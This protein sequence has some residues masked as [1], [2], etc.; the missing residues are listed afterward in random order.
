M[1]SRALAR[2][3]PSQQ[4]ECCSSASATGEDRT[5]EGMDQHELNML[6]KMQNAVEEEARREKPTLSEMC[7]WVDAMEARE[8]NAVHAASCI[9]GYVPT[10]YVRSLAVARALYRFME[11]AEK[12]REDVEM[13]FRATKHRE[14]RR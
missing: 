8:R 9:N 6:S 13:M 4:E 10:A 1:S 3:V 11:W 12:Y 14:A 7:A 2:L 5:R